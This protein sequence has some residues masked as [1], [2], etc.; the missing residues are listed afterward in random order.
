MRKAVSRRTSKRLCAFKDLIRE[1]HFSGGLTSISVET[2][3]ME[4]CRID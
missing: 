4:E 1:D 2:P 3:G